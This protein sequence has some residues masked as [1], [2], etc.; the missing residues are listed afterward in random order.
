M[1]VYRNTAADRLRI[2]VRN[3]EWR[4]W[5]RNREQ[6]GVTM[7]EQPNRNSDVWSSRVKVAFLVFAAIG[8]F[9]LIAE[10]RAH[11]VPFLPWLFLAACP[12]M[13]VFMHGDHG[14][15]RRPRQ[16][17]SARRIE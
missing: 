7:A 11:V 15:A 5:R 16:P 3:G 12:L 14:G 4:R 1:V 9:L 10:H 17:R 8:A 6:V 2:V 13:H